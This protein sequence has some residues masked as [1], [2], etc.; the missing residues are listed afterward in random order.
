MKL[1][2][3]SWKWRDCWEEIRGV[4]RDNYLLPVRCAKTIAAV[5]KNIYVCMKKWDEAF[6]AYR[7]CYNLAPLRAVMEN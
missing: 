6:S 5:F 3:M 7:D 1:H 4:E 2:V